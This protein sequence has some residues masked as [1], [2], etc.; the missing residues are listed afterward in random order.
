LV[1]DS[2][3][4]SDIA[5]QGA[6]YSVVIASNIAA[7]FT[8]MGALAGLMW[9]KILSVK[10]LEISYLDFL[11]VGITITPIVFASALIALYVRLL[12]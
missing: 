6:A 12:F 5:F 7:S 11:K 10:G 1:S 8:I 2:F 9:K 3:V 4:V